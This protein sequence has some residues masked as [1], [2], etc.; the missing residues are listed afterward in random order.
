MKKLDS[1]I[2]N[3]PDNSPISITQLSDKEKI[4]N[5][6]ESPLSEL[7]SL[8]GKRDELEDIKGKWEKKIDKYET[9]I[10]DLQQKNEE[11]LTNDLPEFLK[12]ELKSVS[13]Q[14][15]I[16]E[17]STLES[18]L[19]SNT[20]TTITKK[21]ST[22]LQEFKNKVALLGWYSRLNDIEQGNTSVSNT[23][24]K[25][26]KQTI[27]ETK[28][29]LQKAKSSLKKKEKSISN[30][31]MIQ[32]LQDEVEEHLANLD[33]DF[34]NFENN[35]NIDNSIITIENKVEK[36]QKMYLDEKTKNKIENIKQMV[37]LYQSNNVELMKLKEQI[38]SIKGVEEEIER[39]SKEGLR[40]TKLQEEIVSTLKKKKRWKRI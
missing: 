29:K 28:E 2:S 21:F 22:T 5:Q 13:I 7:K 23:L 11:L 26:N 32:S 3:L 39:L 35:I 6:W 4:L 31:D 30:L 20:T 40:N 9:V 16:T 37:I 24:E 34:I 12:D 17:V 38:K 10:M 25:K 27:I 8:L 18:N 33:E 19:L 1:H 36:L 15:L 14:D